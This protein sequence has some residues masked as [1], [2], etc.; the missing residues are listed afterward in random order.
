MEAPLFPHTRT[1]KEVHLSDLGREPDSSGRWCIPGTALHALHRTQELNGWYHLHLFDL[2]HQE[3]HI[4]PQW[5]PNGLPSSA[6][7]SPTAASPAA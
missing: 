5:P 1:G 6:H 4:N 2:P 3:L 7:R